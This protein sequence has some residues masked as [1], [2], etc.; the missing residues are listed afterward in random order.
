MGIVRLRVDFP[1]ENGLLR[2]LLRV[3]G[4]LRFSLFFSWGFETLFAHS[5]GKASIGQ[6]TTSSDKARVF[7]GFF[8]LSPPKASETVTDSYHAISP[9]SLLAPMRSC[10]PLSLPQG[11]RQLQLPCHLSYQPSR[12]DALM[13]SPELAS[14][15]CSVSP[16]YDPLKIDSSLAYS[17][18]R[19]I[20]RFCPGSNLWPAVYMLQTACRPEKSPSMD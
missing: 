15:F 2:V 16:Y 7:L 4:R 12:P 3:V 5:K 6:K 13:P 8:R 17:R 14:G 10:L 11:R 18:D 1:P 20:P 9:I 19:S